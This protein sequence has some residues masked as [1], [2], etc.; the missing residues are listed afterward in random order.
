MHAPRHHD[1]DDDDDVGVAFEVDSDDGD[2]VSHC[3]GLTPLP[4]LGRMAFP[5]PDMI[6]QL[7]ALGRGSGAATGL[8]G[9]AGWVAVWAGCSGLAELGFLVGLAG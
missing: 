4:P 9:F 8:A 6:A 1:D 5:E 7:A 3:H 2:G